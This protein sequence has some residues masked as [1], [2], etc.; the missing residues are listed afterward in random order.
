M[1][2]FTCLLNRWLDQ[3]LV[4][5]WMCPEISSYPTILVQFQVYILI[6]Y[7]KPFLIVNEFHR[8]MRFNQYHSIIFHFRKQPTEL[9]YQEC[10]VKNF[11]KF[12]GKRLS[13]SLLFNKFANLKSVILLKKTLTQ[14]FSQEFWKNFKNTFLQNTSR[15]LPLHF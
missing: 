12:R 9:F 1:Y 15:R 6:H 8:V 2:L 11:S 7:Y 14:V 5:F 10:G 3:Y 13:Q 4:G